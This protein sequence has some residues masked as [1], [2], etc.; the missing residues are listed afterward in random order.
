[1]SA[2]FRAVPAMMDVRT[3]VRP[4]VRLKELCSEYGSDPTGLVD[5]PL[6]QIDLSERWNISRSSVQKFLASRQVQGE[7]I[8]RNPLQLDALAILGRQHADS[9]HSSARDWF[10][11]ITSALTRA[12]EC[13]Q[14]DV[15]LA[16]EQR[17]HERLED[18]ERHPGESNLLGAPLARQV[19]RAQPRRGAFSDE[20]ESELEEIHS[21]S[22][23]FRERADGR[24][25]ARPTDSLERSAQ[26]ILR[27]GKAPEQ[28][29]VLVLRR[30]QGRELRPSGATPPWLRNHDWS[31]P[32]WT[33]ADVEELQTFW[34]KYFGTS[35][36]EQVLLA[37]QLWQPSTAV[38]ALLELAATHGL[39]KPEGQILEA[40]VWGYHKYFP[41]SERQTKQARD[42]GR[43]RLSAALRSEEAF[44]TPAAVQDH[45]AAL[46]ALSQP[47]EIILERLAMQLILGTVP[48]DALSGYDSHSWT[49]SEIEAEACRIIEILGATS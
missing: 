2:V 5:V 43:D 12:V 29:V 42:E 24:A 9:G 34:N 36:G 38:A 35:L 14:V 48:A 37:L 7:V 3:P 11:V 41:V 18:P 30:I 23:G 40:A 16:L 13:G 45:I 22:K 20:S 28:T 8:S 15:V 47:R 44:S 46:T 26:E 31:A 27:G 21:D 19:E 49:A 10:E 1:M 39:R 25:Q 4:S 32:M 17:L 33:K 6:T